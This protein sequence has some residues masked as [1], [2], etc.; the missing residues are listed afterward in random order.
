M[1]EIRNKGNHEWTRINTNFLSHRGHRGHRDKN[2]IRSSTG[3]S[4]IK[5]KI[6]KLW[7]PFGGN[8]WCGVRSAEKKSLGVDWRDAEILVTVKRKNLWCWDRIG[9]IGSDIGGVKTQPIRLSL[10]CKSLPYRKS[11]GDS[12]LLFRAKLQIK[13]K[14]WRL[15]RLKGQASQWRF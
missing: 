11:E 3:K 1:S 5:D 14:S 12:S 15:L 9:I 6:S 2:K 13:I 10:N 7:K 4:K 8:S